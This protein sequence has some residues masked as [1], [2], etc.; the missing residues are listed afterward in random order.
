MG[1]NKRSEGA[2]MAK[3][4]LIKSEN[5]SLQISRS[6]EECILQYNNIYFPFP[7]EQLENIQEALTMTA[8]IFFMEHPDQRMCMKFTEMTLCFTREEVNELLSLLDRAQVEVV[9]QQLNKTI[10]F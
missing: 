5:G 8:A 3:P 6:Y 7:T 4:L 1:Y 10:T 2:L 9:R